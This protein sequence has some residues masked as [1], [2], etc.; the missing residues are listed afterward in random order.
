MIDA[1]ALSSRWIEFLI[2]SLGGSKPPQKKKVKKNGCVIIISKKDL[3]IDYYKHL[4]NG[5][6]TMLSFIYQ[7]VIWF[8][9]CV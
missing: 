6:Q 9:S 2:R 3:Y 1:T 8:F 4:K 7:K 5:D